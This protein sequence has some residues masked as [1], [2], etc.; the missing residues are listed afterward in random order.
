MPQQ[1][2]KLG[3]NGING[4]LIRDL[5]DEGIH[6]KISTKYTIAFTKIIK[7]SKNWKIV[8]Y[9]IDSKIMEAVV[10]AS[11]T[12]D[13][14]RIWKVRNFKTVF[15]GKENDKSMQGERD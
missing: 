10:E 1:V 12:G 7:I 14:R 2:L 11:L 9:F 15:R 6:Q 13:M 3:K 5:T 8:A 4:N